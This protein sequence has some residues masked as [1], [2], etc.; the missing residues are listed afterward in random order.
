MVLTNYGSIQSA[1][2]DSLQYDESVESM[3]IKIVTQWITMFLFIWTL[4]APVV[5]TGREFN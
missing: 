2:Q 5:C 1:E 3:W 4:I